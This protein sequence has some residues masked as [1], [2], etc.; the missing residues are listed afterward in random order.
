MGRVRRIFWA[1]A[2]PVFA[3]LLFFAAPTVRCRA[4]EPVV[5]VIDPGHGGENRGGEVEGQFLEK[6]ITLQAAL[7]MKQTLEQFEGVEV[8]LTRTADQELSLEERAQLAKA[9]GADFLF[10]LHFNM[11]GEHNLYGS[12]IWTSAFGRY[13][14]AGQTFGRLQ[15]AEMAARGQYIRGVKTRLNSRGTDYYGV[16]RASRQLDLPCVIIEHCYMDHPVDSH[17]IDTAA[18]VADMGV[19]DAI[20]VARYFHLKSSSLG[21]DYSGYSYETVPYAQG[22]AVPDRTP[23]ELVSLS[24]LSADPATGRVDLKLDAADAQ[25][26]ILYYSYS[27]DGGATWS[28]LMPFANLGSLTFTVTVPGGNAPVILCRAYNGYDLY[29]ESAAVAPGVFPAR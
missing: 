20:A 13:Y 26:G 29:A 14:S 7:A 21:L 19:G 2:F 3:A 27:L 25:S 12:E 4:S 24:V 15:L 1:A 11:S 10:S 8:Y 22:V 23:P 6:E 9:M 18:E 17:Q 5:V 28:M 16:I